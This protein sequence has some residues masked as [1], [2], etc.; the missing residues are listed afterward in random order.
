MK[1]IRNSILPMGKQYGAINLFGVLFVKHSMRLTPEVMIHEKI[2]TAQMREL[3]FI[4]FYILYVLEWVLRLIQTR[5]KMHSAYHR[6]SFEKEAYLYASDL[7]YLNHRRAFAQWHN[8][9]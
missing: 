6:I 7:N 9:K 3:F 8:T 5:G 2:H 1:V 4:P